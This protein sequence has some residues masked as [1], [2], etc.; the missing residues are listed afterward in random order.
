MKTQKSKSIKESLYTGG[1]FMNRGV[2]TKQMINFQKSAFNHTFDIFMALKDQSEKIAGNWC[3]K[4]SIFPE[5][6]KIFMNDWTRMIEKGL[7]EYKKMV[8]AGFASMENYL[9]ISTFARPMETA[10]PPSTIVS[11]E[12]VAKQNEEPGNQQ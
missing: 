10:P 11:T 5:Q 1:N 6:G 2:F 9:E 7:E 12:D 8:N 3:E 4:N